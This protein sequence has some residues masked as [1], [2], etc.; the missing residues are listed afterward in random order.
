MLQAAK[1]TFLNC[2]FRLLNFNSIGLRQLC[3]SNI[4]YIRYTKDN[5][6]TAQAT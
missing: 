1:A 4:R 5:R 6:N 2:I 3:A